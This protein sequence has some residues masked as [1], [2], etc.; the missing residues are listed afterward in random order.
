[1][2]SATVTINTGNRCVVNYFDA[3]K[4]AFD[5]DLDVRAYLGENCSIDKNLRGLWSFTYSIVNGRERSIKVLNA[6]PDNML[7][8]VD[9][10]NICFPS[11]H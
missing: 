2:N 11:R 4:R 8:S 3:V 9:C 7:L 6:D 10:T 5:I 1:M